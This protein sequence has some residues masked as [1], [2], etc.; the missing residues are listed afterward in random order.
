MHDM[1]MAGFSAGG[2]HCCLTGGNLREDPPQKTLVP[3]RPRR[4]GPTI[5]KHAIHAGTCSACLRFAGILARMAAKW[6][7]G[8]GVRQ[9]VPTSGHGWPYAAHARIRARRAPDGVPAAGLGEPKLRQDP[10]LFEPRAPRRRK[11]VRHPSRRKRRPAPRERPRQCGARA[12]ALV[13]DTHTEPRGAASGAEPLMGYTVYATYSVPPYFVHIL[14][15][16]TSK[17]RCNPLRVL[18]YCVMCTAHSDANLYSHLESGSRNIWVASRNTPYSVRRDRSA[19]GRALS[20]HGDVEI[21]ANGTPPWSSRW[22]SAR[23]H[24]STGPDD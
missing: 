14:Y 16:Q 22:V 21:Q 23:A 2:Q 10:W 8:R 4:P 6:R 15:F 20:G 11:Q 12:D 24:P 18:A 7:R 9:H 19:S 5:K 3:A 17:I 13:R 1:H